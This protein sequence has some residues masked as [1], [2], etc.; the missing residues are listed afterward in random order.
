M[1]LVKDAISWFEIPVSD[2]TRAKTF[3]QTIFDFEM[4]EMDMGHLK[5]G[6]FLYD[7]D[8]GGVGGA[9]CF[10]E[11]Y[12]PAGS[13][14]PKAYLNGGKDLQI[15]LNRIAGAGG[16]MVMPKTEI[17]PGMGHMAFFLD[18]EGNSVGLYSME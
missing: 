18:S 11:G 14:G 17:A 8:N 10:G 13:N 9:I 4:P 3:Y 2:F 16:T 7:R 6:I 5:M 1:E 15:V 12:K